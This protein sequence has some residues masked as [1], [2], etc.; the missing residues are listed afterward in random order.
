[1]SAEPVASFADVRVAFRRPFRPAVDALRGLDLRVGRGDLLGLLGP[2]GAG[3]TTAICCLLGLLRPD[4]GEVVRFGRRVTTS[5]RQLEGERVGVLLEETRLPPFLTARQTLR[6]VC[7]L[8]GLRGARQNKELDRIVADFR[9]EPLLDRRC[10]SL[11]RGQARR[12]GLA[13]ALIAD[14]PLLILDEPSAGLDAAVRIEFE[15]LLEKLRKRE[16]TALI[17]SHL[18]G[19]VESACTHVAVIKDGRAVVSGET[20]ILLD[21]ARAEGRSEI[22]VSEA[23]AVALERQALPFERSRYPGLLKLTSDLDDRELLARLQEA[24]VFPRRVEPGTS[25]ASFYLDAI[26]EQRPERSGEYDDGS[27]GTEK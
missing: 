14:P 22:H 7:A 1:M 24:G 15:R 25:L 2:N 5:G 3:K 4:G 23:D 27:A 18:L 21:R 9:I 19:E 11:S 26:G 20:R 17:A 8:R 12:I 10:A 6:A 13:A 16:R